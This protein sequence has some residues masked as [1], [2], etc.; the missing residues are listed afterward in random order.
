MT[1]WRYARI[2]LTVLLV[3][4]PM[5]VGVL[6][7]SGVVSPAAGDDQTAPTNT[8]LPAVTGTAALGA[9]LTCD[10]GTWTGNPTPAISY[11]WYRDGSTPIGGATSSTYVVQAADQGHSLS[12]QV[13]ASNGVVGSPVTASSNSVAIPAATAPPANT[14]LPAVTGT[15]A[16]GATLTC[17]GGTW[18]GNPTPAIS[19]QW[20]RDGS[21]PI[22]GATS[23]TYV[24]QAADQG[25]SLSC[26]VTASNGV[27]GSPVTASSNSVAIPAATAPPANT[28]LPAVTGTA[29]LGATLTCDGGTWTGNPTPAISYQWYRDGSTPIGGATS[30]TY[31]VQAADQGHSLSCQ[32]TASNGV[33][34]SPVTASSNSVAIP[35][36]TAPPANTVLPAVTG[37]AA[38]G[39]TLTCD[40]GTWT[41]N[42]TPAISYQWYRDGSTPIGGATSS[43]YVVQAADQGHS[44]SCQVTASNGVVG[45]PVTASSNSVVVG[46]ATYTLS[47]S[48][49]GGNGTITASSGSVTYG[50]PA[51]FTITPATG[52]SLSKLT[53]NS[54]D[55]TASVSNNSYNIASVTA[56]HTLVASFALNSY[57]VTPSAGANGTI[58]PATVQTVDYGAT[59]RLHDHAGDRLL[60][61]RGQRR[62][63]CGR[64]DREP[65]PGRQ[66]RRLLRVHLRRRQRRT[67]D[68]R[69]LRHQ[70]LHGHAQRRGQRHHQP[71]HRADG[72]LRRHARLHDHA[73]DRLLRQRGQR[74]RRCGRADREPEPGRQRD[75]SYAYTFAAVSAAHTISASFAINTYTITPSAGANGSISPATVQTVNY[76]ATPGFTIT[77]ATGYSVSG[78][79][80]D[81]AA[82]ALTGNPNRSPTPT[83]PTRTPSPPSAPPTRSRQ[84]RHQDLHDHA[85]RRGQR[86][87]QPG[88]RADGQLR[89]HAELHD[90]AGDRLLGQR[91]QRR[92]RSVAL[93]GN[94]NLVA[95][96]DGSYAYTFAAVSAA[97]TISASF[98]INTYTI[99]PSA[100]A[101]GSISPATVQTVNYGA[102]P[103][104][105][106]T[107]ATGY[108]VADVQ[109]DGVSVGPV[110]SYTFPAVNA[111]AHDQRQLR[112]RRAD[113]ALDQCRKDRRQL[114]ELHAAHRRALRLRR[115]RFMRWAWATGRSPC[116]ARRRP[117]DRGW[118]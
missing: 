98:A 64:A 114:W 17:D 60:R 2:V 48:A 102:T 78:V 18:T 81:G 112:R 39:A 40:G 33:V 47:A 72:R 63:R 36:A 8:V 9:T 109:V 31:V 20:Y 70:D 99:T 55:V 116:K 118:T 104:F 12:C 54:V 117:A 35:A 49:P 115:S 21:T 96:A 103:S 91:G 85:Q 22:G 43:T 30:S 3:L 86:Q 58:S 110:T 73:G 1:N 94:P 88:H 61:Q 15:A 42:P 111:Q 108:Y 97:H 79:S 26:Q 45:S 28:V 41:G 52:Y 6:A 50:S 56:N 106:I 76:G 71:G 87:H 113:A 5:A 24:V 101:N 107:P 82:V 93:T 34:G 84:L 16:L 44:L 19:Y 27:V 7:G 37:T 14:V 75:G 83:A 13:T 53:D 77:P 46:F 62:R 67:H 95:N 25:H 10:G 100:G 90:H 57:T 38:L 65:E 59:P 74:R 11:Q 69:Q 89:R 23:S 32:V 29:A 92:R 51:S 66:R 68:Q 80:V 4:S 105:T